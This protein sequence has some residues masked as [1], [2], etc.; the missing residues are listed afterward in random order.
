MIRTVHAWLIA[1]LLLAP[2]TADAGEITIS[3]LLETMAAVKPGPD[4][5]AACDQRLARSAT[6]NGP[7]LFYGVAVCSAAQRTMDAAFFMMAGQNRSVADMTALPPASETEEEKMGALYGI[8]FY[9]LGGSGPDDL[10]APPVSGK[11][12][13]ARLEA[14]R[15]VLPA[16]YNPGWAV[17]SPPDPVTYQKALDQ[18]RADRIG[19]LRVLVELMANPRY[20]ALDLELAELTKR[21]G[22]VFKGGTKDAKRADAIMNEMWELDPR[23]R[24]QPRESFEE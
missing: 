10:Y 3:N 19:Q 15:P 11:E 7:N 12:I 6:D 13:L 22:G 20:R 1:A 9:Q 14:W 2:A 4:S 5:S 17:A 8:I 23:T 18:A 21:N 16:G 24:G